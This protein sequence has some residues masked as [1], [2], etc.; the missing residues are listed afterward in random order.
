[1]SRDDSGGARKALIFETGLNKQ[2]SNVSTE[3]MKKWGDEVFKALKAKS[4]K[5]DDSPIVPD[6][7]WSKRTG[8]RNT[9]VEAIMDSVCTHPLTTKTV[10]DA[11]KMEIIPLER[12]LSKDLQIILTFLGAWMKL[13]NLVLFDALLIKVSFV[14]NS[15]I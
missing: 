11:L 10:T 6:K 9:D 4:A 3:E 14:G 8:G 15:L 13:K 2:L 5:T 1:M 12:D 7:M